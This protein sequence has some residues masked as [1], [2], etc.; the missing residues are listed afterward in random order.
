MRTTR[1]VAFSAMILVAAFTPIPAMATSLEVTPF[2]GY[3]WGGEFNDSVTGETLK[4]DETANYGVMVDFKQDEQSQIE[5]YFSRQATQLKANE[6]LFTGNPLFD[7]DI[8]YFHVGGTYG[9][10]SGKVRPFVVGSLGAT[11]MVPKGPGLDALT[12]FSLSLGGGVKLFATDR[13]GLRL[14]GRWFGTLFNGSGSAF[15][16]SGACAISVQG[17]LFS[18]FTTNAGVFITF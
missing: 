4:V 5:L 11:H 1:L 16:S 7:L 12:K 17:D 15:C 13:V 3:T 2:A 9:M 8:E 6:R 14:E 10:D 18:Q